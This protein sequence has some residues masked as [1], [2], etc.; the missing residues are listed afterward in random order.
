M[1]A[2]I[3]PNAVQLFDRQALGWKRIDGVERQLKKMQRLTN[4]MVNL[5]WQLHSDIDEVS[6]EV[7]QRTLPAMSAQESLA[8]SGALALE[9]E[10]GAL[11]PP[12][13][14]TS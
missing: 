4:H 14:S 12:Q 10:G 6:I 9:W 7:H 1:S 5:L 13:S 2:H 3:L 11:P 8:P